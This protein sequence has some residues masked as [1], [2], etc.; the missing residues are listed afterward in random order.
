MVEVGTVGEGVG[1]LVGAE[2]NVGRGVELGV[3]EKRGVGVTY[4]LRVNSSSIN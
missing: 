4:S 1:V 3:G 2:V